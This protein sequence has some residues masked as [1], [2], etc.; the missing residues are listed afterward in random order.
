MTPQRNTRKKDDL[1]SSDEDKEY[2][3]LPVDVIKQIDKEVAKKV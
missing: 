3:K 1:Y 2:L